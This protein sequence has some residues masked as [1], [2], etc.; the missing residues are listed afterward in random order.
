MNLRKAERLRYLAGIVGH[1][2]ALWFVGK[3]IVTREQGGINRGCAVLSGAREEQLNTFLQAAEKHVLKINSFQQWEE[4]IA[5]EK[6]VLL[7]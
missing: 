7:Y 1:R 5:G 2:H 3:I 4:F 6:N